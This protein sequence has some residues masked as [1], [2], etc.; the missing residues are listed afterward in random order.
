MTD[1]SALT[2]V[3]SSAALILVADPDA[4]HLEACSSILRSAGF[5]VAAA[6]DEVSALAAATLSVSAIII[7]HRVHTSSGSLELCRQLRAAANTRDLPVIV[8]T[9]F[10]DEYTRE[11][12]V[13]AGATAILIEPLKQG[14]LVRR[15]RRLITHTGRR[16]RAS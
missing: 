9:A 12:I 15:V 14:L 7:R 16:R 10:D 13:R 3:A 11:Q 2:P 5:E 6:G 8:L 1:A 4:R